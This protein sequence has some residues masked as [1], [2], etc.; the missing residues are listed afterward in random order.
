MMRAQGQASF[1]DTNISV[2]TQDF[3]I[4]GNKPNGEFARN[5]G[6]SRIDI[7]AQDIAL[8]D[9]TIAADAKVS[10]INPVPCQGGPSAGEI[11]LRAQNS[12]TAD[13]SSITNTSSGRAQAGITKIIKDNYFS[14]GA[15]W[16]SPDFA[17]IPTNTVRLTNSE[18]TVESQH[19]G[20]PGY[21]RIRADNILLDHSVL[22]SEVNECLAN[23]KAS[24][25]RLID[26]VGAGEEK[27]RPDGWERCP[28][29]CSCVGEEPGHHRWWNH[30]T[31]PREPYR[32]PYRSPCRSPDD[33]AGDQTGWDTWRATDI[34][35]YGS[36]PGG[37]LR[38]QYRKR[39]CGSQSVSPVKACPSLKALRSRPPRRSI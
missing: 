30:C 20:L 34:R 4:N 22:N 37:D 21:L 19:T 35:P 17:D 5:Q 6:F 13:N 15:I 38:Q 3:D 12:L 18:V 39:R 23:L 29:K 27:S 10:D 24:N 26:V 9:S 2:T 25:G 14:Y 1:T 16:E 7:M 33:S 11:W 32:E 36:D 28:G 31:H 8:R